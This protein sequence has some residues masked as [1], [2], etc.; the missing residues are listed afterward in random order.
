MRGRISNF[1]KTYFSKVNTYYYP[2]IAAQ[3]NQ[4]ADA[5]G[6]QFCAAVCTELEPLLQDAAP[7]FGDNEMLTMTEV[8]L[9]EWFPT[10]RIT[11]CVL[12]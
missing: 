8:S 9:F 11:N 2:A 7:F 4:E 10:C 1:V 5:L 6:A 3:T 12:T